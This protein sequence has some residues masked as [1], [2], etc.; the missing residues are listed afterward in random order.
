MTNSVYS[1]D[2]HNNLYTYSRQL[3]DINVILTIVPVNSL[4]WSFEFIIL[5]K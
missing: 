2:I 4:F 3:D 1:L 5:N